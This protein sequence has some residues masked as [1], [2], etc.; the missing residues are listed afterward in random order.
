MDGQCGKCP[1]QKRL[2]SDPHMEKGPEFCSTL[3][4][5][6]ILKKADALYDQEGIRSFSAAA[7][8]QEASCYGEDPGG[9][10]EKVPLKSRIQEIIEFCRRQGYHRIGLAF[11]SGL[12]NEA[13]VVTEILESHGLEVVSVLCKVGR[14]PK[15]RLGLADSE[16]IRPGTFEPMCNPVA[17][18][19]IM[20]EEKTQFNVVMGLCVGHDSLFLKYSDALCTVLAVKDR[21]LG[22]NPLAAIYTSSSYYKFLK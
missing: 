13:R 20:N 22:H 2:C 6:D 9:S 16:K 7:A 12:R 8:R 21:L 14:R 4:Y 11:C 15:E 3:L 5:E 17:Q 1:M 18:A 10:G 19:L